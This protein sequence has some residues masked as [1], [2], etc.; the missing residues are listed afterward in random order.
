LPEKTLPNVNSDFSLP[1]RSEEANDAYFA[2]SIESKPKNRMLLIIIVI[3]FVVLSAGIFSYYFVNQSQ[4]DSKILD[5]T[6]LKTQEEK[7]AIKYSVG[8]IG[9]DHVHSALT[10]FVHGEMLNFGLPQFQLQSKYIH[11][12]NHNPYLVHK[13]ATGVPLEMLFASFGV[14]ITSKCITLGTADA[15]TDEKFCADSENSMVFMVNGKNVSDITQY[16]I[17]HNDRILISL[18]D[19]K[20]IPEQLKYL[21]SL[22]IYDI[23]KKSS[24]ASEND[25]FV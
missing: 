4:I 10:M 6:S 13:H 19:P 12:E 5:N 25:V 16:E 15:I 24:I 1:G 18:G 9:S 21:E 8:K 17:K 7:M 23:P 20:L 22:Q 3:S 14:D 11:F 2:S